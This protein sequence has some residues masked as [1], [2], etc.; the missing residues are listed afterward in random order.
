MMRRV[1]RSSAYFVVRRRGYG[2]SMVNCTVL[3]EHGVTAEAQTWIVPYVVG[4]NA[5]SG[6]AT[7]RGCETS[8]VSPRYQVKVVR[9]AMLETSVSVTGS[10]M[11]PRSDGTAATAGASVPQTTVIRTQVTLSKPKP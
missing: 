2:T 1:G 9:L 5:I 11:R 4:V 10:P 6:P 8:P 3:A 7:S